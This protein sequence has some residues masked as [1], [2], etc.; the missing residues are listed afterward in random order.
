MTAGMLIFIGL[1]FVAVFLLAQALI[2]PAFGENART[3]RVMRERLRRIQSERENEGFASL[4]RDKY[5][6]EL[7]PFA[8]WLES[9]PFME[10]LAGVIEQAGRTTQAHRVVVLAA[11]LAVVG[12]M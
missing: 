3:R 5:L 2:V 8:R 6:K 11:V 4:V 7:S 10:R 12:A 9:F 1:I